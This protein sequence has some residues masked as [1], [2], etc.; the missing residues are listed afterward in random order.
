[1]VPL[2]R[3]HQVQQ[4]YRDLVVVQFLVQQQ[5]H[6]Q[7]PHHHLRPRPLL[8]HHLRQVLLQVLLHHPHQVLRQVHLLLLHLLFLVLLLLLLLL[9]CFFL[10]L[11]LLLLL[12]L[13][14]GIDR[15]E[16]TRPTGAGIELCLGAEQRRAA[17]DAGVGALAFL[18]VVGVAE[19]PLCAVAP[20]D[21]ILLRRQLGAPFVFGLC[22][23]V[24]LVGHVGSLSVHSKK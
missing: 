17:T 14:V 9:L 18:V 3:A 20:G 8:V 6:L 23:L 21:V 13:V 1:M 15:L 19:G 4:V 7:H 10:L 24:R 11:M 22:D 5:L 16:E 2:V 12:L